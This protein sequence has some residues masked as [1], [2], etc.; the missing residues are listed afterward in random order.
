MYSRENSVYDII[1][2]TASSN[3]L[4]QGLSGI[5]GFP[6][7]LF[8]DIGVVF[9]HYGPMFN[10]IRE[11]YGHPP[12]SADTVKAFVMGCKEEILTDLVVDKV[13]GN[14]PLIGI[15]ANIIAAKSMT[16]RIGIVI[17]MLSARGEE[18]NASN[19]KNATILVRQAFPQRNSLVFKKPS[20][21][22]VV[23]LLN[24]VEGLSVEDVD[25]KLLNILN[26]MAS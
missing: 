13:I 3:I 11:V 4:L 15:P 26:Q 12:V 7:T 25:S 24:V 17:G 16:W 21:E 10:E 2:R 9:T 22:I 19:V 8:A 23:K 14:I 1:G 6:F 20:R 18:I 5:A